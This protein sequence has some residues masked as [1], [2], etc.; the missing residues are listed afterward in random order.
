M[1]DF[2]LRCSGHAELTSVLSVGPSLSRATDYGAGPA[3]I[4]ANVDT[5]LAG[6]L[7]AALLSRLHGLKWATR[8]KNSRVVRFTPRGQRAFQALL[9]AGFAGAKREKRT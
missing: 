9:T 5:I 7:G 4:G 2:E 6:S 8:D 1:V 3:W